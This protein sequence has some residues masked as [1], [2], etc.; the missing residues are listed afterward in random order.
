VVRVLVPHLDGNQRQTP[1]AK[2]RK[3]L[4]AEKRKESPH[5]VTWRDRKLWTPESGWK[6]DF[7]AFLLPEGR[8]F[9]MERC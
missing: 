2:V 9:C 6:S 4:F 8:D 7:I 5:R 3:V 1:A